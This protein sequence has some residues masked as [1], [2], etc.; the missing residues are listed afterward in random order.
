MKRI[1][2]QFLDK[3]ELV[4]PLKNKLVLEVGS[5]D[6]SRSE[7]TALLARHLT[8]IEPDQGKIDTA[9]SRNINNATF[10]RGE[11]QSLPFEISH[12]DV[13]IFALSFHH[14]PFDL[15]ATAIDEAIRVTKKKGLIVFLEP[16]TKG[17]FFEAEI[18]FGL[19]DGDETEAKA[20]AYE[21]MMHHRGLRLFQEIP[22]ETIFQ[23]DDFKETLWI[24]TAKVAPNS[25]GHFIHEHNYTLVAERRINIFQPVRSPD[26]RA[27]T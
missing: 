6:G 19:F 22:D 8:G 20:K 23:S 12:F 14:V 24:E 21:T 13:T 1:K 2:E 11:A 18:K 5:G 15:M 10:L 3:L 17:S 16:G 4:V 25:I 9:R 27:A 26:Y 7:A